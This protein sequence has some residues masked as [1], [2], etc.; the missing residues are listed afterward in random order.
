[1]IFQTVQSGS[2]NSE[3]AHWF[4]ILGSR[5]R[6]LSPLPIF[7]S[8]NPEIIICLSYRKSSSNTELSMLVLAA[9]FNNHLSHFKGRKKV[10]SLHTSYYVLRIS[11]DKILNFLAHL[12]PAIVFR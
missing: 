3:I 11:P 9:T 12:C 2:I 10:C 8:F 6:N 1:M 4:S 7:I 5:K